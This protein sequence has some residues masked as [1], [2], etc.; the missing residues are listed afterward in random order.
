LS[1]A[2]Q[3]QQQHGQQQSGRLV[4]GGLPKAA[5]IES[6]SSVSDGA[7]LLAVRQRAAAALGL[8][9]TESL[10]VI[11]MLGYAPA[12][13]KTS[14]IQIVPKHGFNR[15]TFWPLWCSANVSIN[16]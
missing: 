2:H 15:R 5:T 16:V 13:K 12:S 3:Q 6:P 14:A 8:P 9:G 7:A 1:L 10:Q 4:Q 11:E